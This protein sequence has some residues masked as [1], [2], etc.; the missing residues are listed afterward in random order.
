MDRKIKGNVLSLQ[1][2]FL[3]L[4]SIIQIKEKRPCSV[5]C[6]GEKIIKEASVTLDFCF[7]YFPMLKTFHEVCGTNLSEHS[8]QLFNII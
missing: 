5:C 1:K 7:L 4:P 2:K 3:F 8:F 6:K